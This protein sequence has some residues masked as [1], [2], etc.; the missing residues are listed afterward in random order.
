[1]IRLICSVKDPRNK[2]LY[3]IFQ[4]EKK[5]NIKREIQSLKLSSGDI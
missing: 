2:I 1:M 3:L 4:K 5:K